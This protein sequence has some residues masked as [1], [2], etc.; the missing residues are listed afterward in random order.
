MKIAKS[1]LIILIW[2]LIS[3]TSFGHTSTKVEI[4]CPID[5]TKFTIT[6][7]LSMSVFG[8]A[9]DFQKQGAIGDYYE[10]MINS[11]PKCHYSGYRAD[12]DTSFNATTINEI[13]KII[14]PFK[15]SMM[16][17]VLENEIAVQIHLYLKDKNDEIAHLYLM[18]TYYLKLDST[19][20]AKRKELQLSC[21]SYLKKAIEN[22]EYEE[23]EVYA[24]NLYLIGELYRRIGNFEESII[25]FDL[26]ISDEN[27]A[28]W[29]K[30]VAEN[31]KAMAILKDEKNDM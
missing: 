14:D 26:A 22:R 27:K 31:Q 23:K 4:K 11:C 20:V 9:K 18:A 1:R 21:I 17:D 12:F 25:Y 2:L 16:N 19:R 15:D 3:K 30:E 6:K 8:Y 28:S 7:T 24:N 13:H 29:I 10:V 5:E